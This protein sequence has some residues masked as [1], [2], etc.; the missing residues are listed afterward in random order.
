MSARRDPVAS[1][2]RFNRER[3]PERLALKYKG[4]QVD[5]LAFYR[6]TCHLFW[7][8]W[9]SSSPLDKVPPAW[10][11]GDLHIENFGTYRGDNRLEYFDIADFD[12]ALLAPCTWDLARLA[13]SVLI[14]ARVIGLDAGEGKNLCKTLL[15]AYAIGLEGGKARWID[16][17]IASGL[18]GTLL[19][20]LAHRTRPAFLRKRAET[21]KGKE[22]LRIDGKR[23]LAIDAPLRERVQRA[24]REFAK[25]QPQPKFFDVLDIARRI[26]GTGSLGLERYT[27]LVAGRGKPGG[28]FLLDLKVASPSAAAARAR[29]EQPRWKSDAQR[30]IAVQRRMQAVSPALLH[31]LSMGSRSCILRELMPSQDKIDLEAW[32]KGRVSLEP[33]ARDLG[34]LLAWAQLRSGGRDGSATIDAMID[35]AKDGRWRKPVLEFAHGYE[36]VAWRD[37]KR[38]R[39]AY[40]DRALA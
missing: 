8:D 33:L 36:D 13:T 30:V 29:L 31:D 37:W 19:Q 34:S 15:D 12:E 4:M 6:G 2:V 25:E 35:F 9:P 22:R 5:A 10:T 24:L 32:A 40:R 16:P 39:K 38:F 28:R 27:V 3:D 14:A 11:C 26:A 18:V 1:I 7:D 20:S 17:R 21:H 23:T